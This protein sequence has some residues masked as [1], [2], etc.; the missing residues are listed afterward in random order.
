[1][2][3]VLTLAERNETIE[4]LTLRYVVGDLSEPVY[5]A[6]LKCRGLD[7]DEIRYMVMINQCAHR[8]SL[9]YRRGDV[10]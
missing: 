10:S 7:K 5:T 6:S 8:N 9:A 2:G 3:M 4:G 1:M